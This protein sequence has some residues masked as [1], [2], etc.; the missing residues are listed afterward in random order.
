ME[1]IRLASPEEIEQFSKNAD[2]IPGQSTMVV[3]PNGDKQPDVAVIRH[4]VEM[5]PVIF[6]PESGL[7]RRLFFVCNLETSLRLMGTPVYYCNVLADD[8]NAQ[9][10]SVIEKRGAEPIS[11]APEIRYKRRLQ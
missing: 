8:E 3:F 7:Q 1:D 4:V 5:D 10:R 9:W 6:S 11:M 2:F